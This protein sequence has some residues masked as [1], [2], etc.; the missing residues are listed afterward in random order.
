MSRP[1]SAMTMSFAER[2]ATPARTRRC[3]G[4]GAA[5]TV[6][7]VVTTGIVNRENMATS[8][9]AKDAEFVLQGHHIKPRCVQSVGCARVVFQ[10]CLVDLQTDG[11]RIGIGLTMICHCHNG[12]VDIRPARGNC[13]LEVSCKCGDSAKTRQR[14][15][16]ECQTDGRCHDRTSWVV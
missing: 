15:A 10:P 16:D 14:V 13:L 4:S 8:L 2:S 11:G 6:C 7:S 1:F 12:R 3:A 9:T 5:S